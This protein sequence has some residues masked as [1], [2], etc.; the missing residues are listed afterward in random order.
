M[1]RPYG[2][3]GFCRG[4]ACFALNEARQKSTQMM[5]DFGQKIPGKT[6]KNRLN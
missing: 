3:I 6:P 1:L 5:M 4:K 2:K